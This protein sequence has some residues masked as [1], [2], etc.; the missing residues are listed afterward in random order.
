M[1]TLLFIYNPKA[2]K[3][4]IRGAMADIIEIFDKAGYTVTVRPTKRKGDVA[5]IICRHGDQYERLVV[6][7]GDG[8]L[9]E[10]LNGLK[11]AEEQ[12]K[13][14]PDL[15]YIP[16]GSTNDFGLSLKIPTDPVKAATVAVSGVPFPCDT[17]IFNG[18]PFAYIAAF[19]AFTQ[20]SYGTPQGTKN[21]LGHSAYILEGIKSLP[22]IK[23]VPLTVQTDEETFSGTFLY[24]MVSNTLSLGGI[25]GIFEKENVALDDGLLE[26]F[27]LKEP[28]SIAEQSEM[29]SDLLQFNFQSPHVKSL[30][31]RKITFIAEDNIPWTLDGEFGG[32]PNAAEISVA[33]KAYRILV[34]PTPD[35]EENGR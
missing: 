18:H 7:G 2:G 21:T 23:G 13:K 35:P 24:G 28:K 30:K 19:G 29:V 26:V 12:G 5:R 14:M 32:E 34:P 9:N 3:S 20:V 11:Q 1:K 15:G 16:T 25:T 6:A 33:Q 17:G 27:L 10:A 31:T 8:T 22:Q 4:K